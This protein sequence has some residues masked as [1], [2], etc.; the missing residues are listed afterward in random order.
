L[1]DLVPLK[2]PC[3]L[4]AMVALALPA[5]ALAVEAP[6][7]ATVTQIHPRV[8]WRPSGSGSKAIKLGAALH[9]G[10][11][12]LT[13]ATGSL[14]FLSADGSMVNLGPNTEMTLLQAR[15]TA[16]GDTIFG[17]IRGLF[18]AVVSRQG[19]ASFT[20]RTPAGL[21][22]VKGT[23]WQ[24]EA[25]PDRSEVR[26]LSGTVE[27]KD[28]QGSATVLVQAGEG[29]TSFKD[30]VASVRQLD[31]AEIDALKA[32]FSQRVFQAKQDY[33]QR[34]KQLQGN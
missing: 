34:V 24:I 23:Q 8:E 12:V 1:G 22:G 11:K 13:S 21:A 14:G 5:L 9:S 15:T 4:A 18:Q 30:R 33:S 16:G 2:T 27:V 10:D 20:V 19:K 6:I 31:K 32:A 3:L 28:P 29:T 7:A 17:L 26:V 25:F